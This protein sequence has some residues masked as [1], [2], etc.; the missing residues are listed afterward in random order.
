MLL[1]KDL[2]VTHARLLCG[3]LVAFDRFAGRGSVEACLVVKIRLLRRKLDIFNIA[4]L[5]KGT[6]VS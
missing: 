1:T 5:K 3:R 2:W 4:E 6:R